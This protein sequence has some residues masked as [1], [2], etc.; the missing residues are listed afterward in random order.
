MK[1][2]TIVKPKRPTSRSTAKPRSTSSAANEAAQVRELAWT[3]QHAKAIELATQLLASFG[4]SGRPR[5]A[6]PMS[7][8]LLDLR[9][10]S[11]GDPHGKVQ[12]QKR[13]CG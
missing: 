12:S 5:G 2:K 10:E 3:G 6:A 1:K 8:E 9:A 4:K 11:R 7:M 13:F